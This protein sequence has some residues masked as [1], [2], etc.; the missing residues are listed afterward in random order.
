MKKFFPAIAV[1]VI[2]LGSI[3]ILNMGRGL[4]IAIE[5]AGNA[6]LGVPV[7]AKGVSLSLKDKTA[8]IS[9]LT[10]GSPVGFKEK[11]ML[12]TGAITLTLGDITDQLIVVKEVA[13]DTARVTYELGAEGS[14]FEALQKNMKAQAP[15]DDA[16]PKSGRDLAIEH[17]KIVN[18]TV[19]ATV[20]DQIKEVTL[21]EISLKNIGTSDKPATAAQV[22]SQVMG[23]IMTTSSAT[24]IKHNIGEAVDHAIDKAKEAIKGVFSK[25]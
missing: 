4:E 12:T 6:A 8:K 2:A 13:I 3:I 23:K 1:I 21:P 18:A 17:L 25:E 16:A 9:S 24:L 19:A 7:D 22:A 20:A 10:I 14:N 5:K 15:T 11:N